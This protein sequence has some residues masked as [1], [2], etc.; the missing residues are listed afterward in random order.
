MKFFQVLL[1]VFIMNHIC[2][3]V[4]KGLIT[5]KCK[6]QSACRTLTKLRRRPKATSEERLVKN[7]LTIF[8]DYISN[9]Q[10][11]L[12][13]AFIQSS[14]NHLKPQVISNLYASVMAMFEKAEQVPLAEGKYEHV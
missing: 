1:V 4:I 12:A 7:N 5:L 6:P 13:K 11:D 10:I 3:S 14:K 2:I 9:K 8:Y